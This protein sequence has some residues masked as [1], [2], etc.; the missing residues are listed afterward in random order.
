MRRTLAH[1]HRRS[2]LRGAAGGGPKR[3]DRTERRSVW[4]PPLLMVPSSMRSAADGVDG[5]MPALNRRVRD[6]LLSSTD[7]GL[8]AMERFF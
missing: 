8:A 5:G 6:G 1:G 3:S 2:G 7:R 4:Q